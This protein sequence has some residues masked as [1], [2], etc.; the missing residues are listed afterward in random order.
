[1]V[2]AGS[3][4]TRMSSHSLE[5]HDISRKSREGAQCSITSAVLRY[6]HHR[7]IRIIIII[8]SWGHLVCTWAM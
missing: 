6:Y 1:M 2:R 8:P 7:L 4:R 5:R 3:A